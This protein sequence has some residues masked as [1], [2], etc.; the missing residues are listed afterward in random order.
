MV[1]R[2]R[3]DTP[4]TQAVREMRDFVLAH[5]YDFDA[6]CAGFRWPQLEQ[7]NFGLD[8]FDVVAGEHPDRVAVKIVEDDLSWSQWTYG[9]LAERSN[10]VANWLV[11]LG[12]NRGDRIIVMLHNTI[13]LWEVLLGVTKMGG[14][15]IPTSTLLNPEDLAWRVETAGVGFTVC[16]GDLA[17]KLADINPRVTRIG[18]GV[19]AEGWVDYAEVD[20]APAE[21]IPEGPTPA[22]DPCLLYFTSGTTSRPKLVEH[23]HVSYPVGHLST[24][25]WLG[26]R[27]GDV[28]LNISSPGWGK[29]A[30]SNF[31][32]P[33]LA[34]ATVFIFNYSRFNADTLMRI[35]D[36]HEVSSFCAPPTVWRMLIQA[37]LTRLSHPP[38]EIVG[39]GEALNPEVIEKV[40]AAW[41]N[42][43]RDGYGQTEITCAIGNGPGEPIKLGAMGR[44][45]PGYAVVLVDPDSGELVTGIGE[46]EICLDLSVPT[47]ALMNGYYH[48]QALTDE[49][50]RDGY[51]HTGDL[52]SRDADGY[53]TYIGRADDVFKAS[54]YKISPFELESVMMMHDAVAECAVVASPDEVRGAVPK[55][56]VHL[57][58]G[59]QAG[60]DVA[61]SLFAHSTQHLNGYQLVRI[62]EFVEELPKTISA[63]IRR[64]VLRNNEADRV[65]SGDSTGQYFHRDYR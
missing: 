12:M 20:E 14:V 42:T 15:A 43:I 61:R 26:V 30:W 2:G 32:S 35:M 63:K 57:R 13:E 1:Y 28:H 21:F 53:L 9:Q 62:I 3:P 18:I 45:T 19:R 16:A 25:Y 7:F 10:R 59:L 27:P 36:S 44:P 34:Q 5:T 54:D 31:Y 46:G 48:D 65:A 51:Y 47:I 38:R 56:F 6:V 11:G 24:M 33:F 55:A 22:K 4:A 64:V 23:S 37:D 60:P 17:H 58:Q 29:H 41:K 39:A 52:A 8:W 40:R 49:A 50:C